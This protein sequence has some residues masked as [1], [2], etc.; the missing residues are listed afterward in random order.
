MKRNSNLYIFIL[1][2]LFILLVSNTI[3]INYLNKFKSKKTKK[4][5]NISSANL[6]LS[7]LFFNSIKNNILSESN[8]LCNVNY[9]TKALNFIDYSSS[10]L[11]QD[12]DI[13]SLKKSINNKKSEYLSSSS[14]P[15]MTTS[16]SI[17]NGISIA[18]IN[19]L[20]IESLTPYL[21]HVDIATQKTYIYEGSKNKWN[22]VKSF[23]CSTGIKGEDT[24]SGIYTIK[25]R[26]N[27]FFS[28]KYNQGGRY[29]VQFFNDYLFHSTP[30][31]K[32]QTQIVDNTLGT[33]SS[34][35]CIRLSEEDSKWIYDNIPSGS[36]VIIK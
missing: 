19:S 33:P 21:I 35:G 36:K 29:W 27:W 16:A 13:I 34:H 31:N 2:S 30:Y 4:E 18:T 6:E 7:N 15:S 22:L 3:N 14:N 11:K 5:N 24:P 1:F 8:N 10:I 17:L 26:G 20:S 23:L 9:Y 25:E 12:E 32:E 28:E